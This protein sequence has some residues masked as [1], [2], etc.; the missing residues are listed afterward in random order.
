MPSSTSET[1]T[2]RSAV[3]GSFSHSAQLRRSCASAGSSWRTVSSAPSGQTATQ[4]LHP[5]H[6]SG[7]TVMESSPPPPFSRA[8]TASKNG[9]V[10]ASG[11]V[12]SR[13]LTIANSASVSARRPASH[14][15]LSATAV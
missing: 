5:L 15:I 14:P 9:L 1:L 11:N 6:A 3:S 8:S 12:A 4:R 10:R 13:S 7:L 2:N